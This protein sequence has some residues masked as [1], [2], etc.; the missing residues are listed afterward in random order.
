MSPHVDILEGAEPLGRSFA[1]SVVFHVALIGL[2]AGVGIVRTS[3][4]PTLG[5]ADPGGG[6]GSVAVTPVS[7]IPLPATEGPRNPVANDTPSQVPIPKAPPKA[8][9]K[10]RPEPKKVDPN[11]LPVPGGFT[12]K[13]YAQSNKFREQQKDL[14]NQLYSTAGQRLS[15][16][17]FNTTGGRMGL[18]ANAPF[19]TEFG[20]YAEILRN[21]VA[22]AWR[23]SDIDSRIHSAPLVTITFTLHRDGSISG[24]RVS[25]S[26][27][28]VTLDRSAER[29]ILDAAP[30]P[31]MPPQFPKDQTNIDFVFEL[32]R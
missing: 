17:M 32:K 19:G 8:T 11:A 16:E 4:G 14:P 28:F 30:F 1:G 18:G 7:T 26:S 21:R 13:E 25:R 31:R 2:V 3:N 10:P 20:P 23:T 12:K 27:G 6:I 9:V 24:M 15:S 22:N 5:T 29:A